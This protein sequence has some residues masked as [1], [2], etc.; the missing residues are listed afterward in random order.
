MIPVYNLIQQGTRTVKLKLQR[1]WGD[2]KSVLG[3]TI[4]LESFAE[5]HNHILAVKD[6]YLGSPA[7]AAGMQPYKDFIVGT[8]EIAFKTLDDFAKYVEVNVNQEVKLYIY[9]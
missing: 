2:R 9:N 4:R 8:R 1:N 7:R 5:A 6:V 3:A